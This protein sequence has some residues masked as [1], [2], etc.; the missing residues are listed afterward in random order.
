MTGLLL[1]AERRYVIIRDMKPLSQLRQQWT[2][3]ADVETEWL[4]QLTPQESFR[5]FQALQ[6]EFEPQLQA[7]EAIFRQQRLDMLAQVQARLL[8]LN[9]FKRITMQDLTTSLMAV[10]RILTDAGLPS[11]VIGGVAVTVWGEPRLTRDVD[12]K[13]LA[14]REDR[15]QVLAV[16]H[17]YTP[18]H[19]DPAEALRRQGIA[20]FQD[21]AEVRIDI[22]LAETSFDETALARAQ[23]IELQPNQPVRVCTAEDLI[24]YKMLSLR[25]KDQADVESIVRRQGDKLDDA[26]VEDWLLQF[27]QALDDSTLVNEYH[28]LRQQ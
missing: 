14:G 23:T 8:Q 13:I 2:A 26:Y 7:T 3:V 15:E 20:F 4:R 12:I 16:L 11:M 5:Q 10:Q 27:E 19:A 28:R 25:S 6:R 24:I 17:N 9:E 21:E 18:L 22:M 1:P